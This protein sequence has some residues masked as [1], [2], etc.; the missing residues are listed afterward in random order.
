[1][2][3]SPRAVGNALRENP[4]APEVWLFRLGDPALIL[5]DRSRAIV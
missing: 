5:G 4:L 2:K 1:M 3:S